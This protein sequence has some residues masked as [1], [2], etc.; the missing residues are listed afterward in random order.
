MNVAATRSKATATTATPAAI[1]AG[2]PPPSTPAVA[3]L[4]PPVATD[5]APATAGKVFG[6]ILQVLV[7]TFVV[8]VAIAWLLSRF[9]S[10][11]EG[12]EQTALTTRPIVGHAS[13]STAS[14]SAAA[15]F[16]ASS[17][18][19]SSPPVRIHPIIRR[20]VGE[21]FRDCDD[22][23]C[24]Y[25]MVIG[26]GTLQMGSRDDEPGREDD[27]GP[28]HD[29]SIDYVF[30]V[31]VYPVTRGQWRAA[32]LPARACG[33][34]PIH[35]DDDYPQSCIT[36]KDAHDYVKWL[37]DKT[38]YS[39][40]LLSEAEYEY[41]NRGGILSTYFWGDTDADRCQYANGADPVPGA[42]AAGCDDHY[43]YTSP[44]AS[45]KPNYYGL[46]DTTGNVWSWTQDCYHSSYVGAPLDGSAWIVGDCD[47]RMIRGGAWN[48]AAADLRSAKRAWLSIAQGPDKSVGLRIA[49]TLEPGE[50]P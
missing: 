36:W 23:S 50:V 43:A 45:F 1:G 39:Y 24:P 29:V 13:L 8:V 17:V 35:D 37:S 19:R 33:L 20:H 26:T 32:G 21:T 38:G 47:R 9:A 28:L 40:R 6:A 22:D 30:G 10:V 5:P 31:G 44:V 41:I 25:V 14:A 2:P 7:G 27:E 16:A 48:S 49:R 4:P 11:H 34:P 3:A 15:A 12:A 46:Y 18:S 42:K